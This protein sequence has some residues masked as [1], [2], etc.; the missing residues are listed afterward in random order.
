MVPFWDG[1]YY[2]TVDSTTH[3]GSQWNV[4]ENHGGPIKN[5]PGLQNRALQKA[6]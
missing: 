6:W 5:H 2:S 3:Q 4:S 1:D